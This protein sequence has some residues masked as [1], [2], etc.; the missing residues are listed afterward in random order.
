MTGRPYKP[1][2]PR[3]VPKTVDDIESL[4]PGF[5]STMD[6]RTALVRTMRRNYETLLN[7]IGGAGEASHIKASLAERFVFLE[8][9]LAT[10]EQEIA[11]GTTDRDKAVGRWTQ[12][13]NSLVGL[14]K[15]LGPARRVANAPWL[16]ATV[17]EV[18]GDD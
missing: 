6:G 16:D 1:P 15:V 5:L 17:N 2:A 9:L 12:A 13:V 10:L 18:D 7:D 14:A 3:A 11:A 4:T 8:T